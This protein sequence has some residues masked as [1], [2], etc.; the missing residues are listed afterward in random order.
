MLLG[1]FLT[2]VLQLTD[3]PNAAILTE[4]ACFTC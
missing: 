3:T 2:C 1:L 4:V